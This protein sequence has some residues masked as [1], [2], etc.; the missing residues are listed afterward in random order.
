[1]AAMQGC[2]GRLKM[3]FNIISPA[4]ILISAAETTR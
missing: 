2:G 3:T 1:M 4:M